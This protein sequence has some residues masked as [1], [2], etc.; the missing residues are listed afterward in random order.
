MPSRVV[1]GQINESASL[2]RVSLA[3]DLTFRALLVAVDDFG[4][5]DARPDVMKARLFPTRAEMT[6]GR[7][8]ACVRELAALDDPPVILYEEDGRPFL[9][10]P[11]WELHRSGGKRAARSRYPE[12][13]EPSQDARGS[14]RASADARGSPRIPDDPLPRSEKR[15]ASSEKREAR[16]REAGASCA[17]VPIKKA[18]SRSSREKSSGPTNAEL[19]RLWQDHVRPAFLA[20]GQHQPETLAPTRRGPMRERM[21][22]QPSRP[23]VLTEIVHGYVALRGLEPKADWDPRDH[24]HPETLFRP[25]KAAMYLTAYDRAIQ[26]GQT[27]PFG[28]RGAQPP[29]GRRRVASHAEWDAIGETR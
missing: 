25:S 7:V 24:F 29:I 13:P 21:R 18:G 6:P 12:P 27:P 19:E 28:T 9:Y 17:V 3:A 10:L 23:G 8:E 22:E 16:K 15:E 5:L 1:R 26:E 11:K 2:S 14:P 4:R 20:Y